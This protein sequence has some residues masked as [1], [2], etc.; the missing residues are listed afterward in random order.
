MFD[1]QASSRLL[2]E[3]KHDGMKDDLRGAATKLNATRGAGSATG[4][5]V[6]VRTM[7][8]RRSR[9]AFLPGERTLQQ[10]P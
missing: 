6:G 4:A 9:F 2:V 7:T 10:T 1:V 3:A 5:F 8:I